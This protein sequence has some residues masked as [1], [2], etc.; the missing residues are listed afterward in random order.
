MRLK[1]SRR[2]GKVRKKAEAEQHTVEQHGVRRLASYGNKTRN[3]VNKVVRTAAG[4]GGRWAE[5]I[6]LCEIR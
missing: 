1:S 3:E 5:L 6:A 4:R 2:G